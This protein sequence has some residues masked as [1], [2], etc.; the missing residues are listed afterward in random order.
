MPTI[1]SGILDSVR[2][3]FRFSLIIVPKIVLVAL[4]L[5]L[6]N[7]IALC[8]PYF[9]WH[10]WFPP[11]HSNTAAVQ[12]T[13]GESPEKNSH[14][15]T[16]SPSPETAQVAVGACILGGVLI[17]FFEGIAIFS[18]KDDKPKLSWVLRAGHVAGLA[19]G[20]GLGLALVVL[21]VGGCAKFFNWCHRAETELKLKE[22]ALKEKGEGW[23]KVEVESKDGG[24]EKKQ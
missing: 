6:A 16:T 12:R 19:I 2:V 4:A 3:G 11:K 24:K 23:E 7:S 15:S 10:I 18:M 22:R 5:A 9:A 1:M 14:N 8:A 13:N 20:L 17:A 21:M